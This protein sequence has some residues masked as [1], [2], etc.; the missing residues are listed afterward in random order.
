MNKKHKKPHYIKDISM[1]K[2]IILSIVLLG[3]QIV[4]CNDTGPKDGVASGSNEEI[5]STFD[6]IQGIHGIAR[7]VAERAWSKGLNLYLRMNHL[8]KPNP[9]D[10]RTEKGLFLHTEIYPSRLY[11]PWGEMKLYNGAYRHGDF[12]DITAIDSIFPEFC[13]YLNLKFVENICE[14]PETA[15]RHLEEYTQHKEV[16]FYKDGYTPISQEELEQYRG[17]E[18][19]IRANFPTCASIYEVVSV[20]DGQE[21]PTPTKCSKESGAADAGPNNW[22]AMV[23]SYH[24]KNNK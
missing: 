2:L 12:Y 22:D 21:L 24:D 7:F 3:N 10:N 5:Q 15:K 1:K 23:K 6:A 17:T 19:E 14:D 8:S 11:T 9:S 4:I 16:K 20:G 18:T 13:K